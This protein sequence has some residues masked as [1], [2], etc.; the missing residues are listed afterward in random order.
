[1]VDKNVDTIFKFI[2]D[3]F[4]PQDLCYSL[5][6]CPKKQIP[7][8]SELVNVMPVNI[9]LKDVN[10]RDSETCFLC[11]KLVKLVQIELKN[12]STKE[13]IITALSEACGL[14]TKN[15][16]KCDK[17]VRNY[18][19]QFIQILSEDIDPDTACL[20][21]GLCGQNTKI[22]TLP[23]YLQGNAICVECEMIAHFIQNKIYDYNTEL[24][25]E[26]YIKNHLCKAMSFVVNTRNCQAFIEQYGPIIM[27]TIAQDVFNPDFLCYKELHLC[28]HTKVHDITHDTKQPVKCEMCQNI[29]QTLINLPNNPNRLSESEFVETCCA[30]F[31]KSEVQSKI[32]SYLI[33]SLF[34]NY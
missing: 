17:M 5:R 30:K 2:Q 1:M 9:S 25:I 34:F 20:L 3:Y 15:K 27:Q 19:E 13:Q 23:E 21:A 18:V 4:Q 16:Q 7:T 11:K 33:K 24:Q 22:N 28:N 29:I 6:I 10:S 32:V 14:L 8:I 12:N 26:E 31:S